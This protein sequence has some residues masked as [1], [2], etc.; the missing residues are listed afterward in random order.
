MARTRRR[1][2][3]GSCSH[4]DKAGNGGED[5]CLALEYH[6]AFGIMDG[7]EAG[8]MKDWTPLHIPVLLQRTWQ[9]PFWPAKNTLA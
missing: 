2:S 6:G 1:A 5:A 9:Y 4:T 8:L 3:C 7:V